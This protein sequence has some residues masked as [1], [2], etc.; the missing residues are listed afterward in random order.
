MTLMLTMLM[1]N[2]GPPS[3]E[4]V[5]FSVIGGGM[6]SAA[7]SETLCLCRNEGRCSR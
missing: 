3:A 5:G 4:K 1:A 7:L 2:P 6:S